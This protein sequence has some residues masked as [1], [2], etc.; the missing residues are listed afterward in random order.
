MSLYFK[1]DD[2]Q[3]GLALLTPATTA[4]KARSKGILRVTKTIDCA[5]P[6][7]EGY[8][9][10]SA[11]SDAFHRRSLA[12]IANRQP[13]N[14]DDELDPEEEEN[15]KRI[16]FLTE[17]ALAQVSEN[18]CLVLKFGICQHFLYNCKR[19]PLFAVEHSSSFWTSPIRCCKKVNR[20]GFMDFFEAY[21]HARDL[22]VPRTA[23]N[24]RSFS[25]QVKNMKMNKTVLDF[26]RR[27]PFGTW[28]VLKDDT[29]QITTLAKSK[30]F[31]GSV[32][33]PTDRY[34]E[35][36]EIEDET[37]VIE[38]EIPPRVLT[39]QSEYVYEVIEFEEDKPELA[40]RNKPKKKQMRPSN[41][42]EDLENVVGITLANNQTISNVSS[43]AH[44][45]GHPEIV[46]TS[47]SSS[48]SV[49]D[50]L[51]GN[52]TNGGGGMFGY[53]KSTTSASAIGKS[54]STILYPG[55]NTSSEAE[56]DA[57]IRRRAFI[58]P[59]VTLH[60]YLTR[61][62]EGNPAW[63]ARIFIERRYD[64]NLVTASMNGGK[65]RAGEIMVV[66]NDNLGSSGVPSTLSE[67]ALSEEQKAR[68]LG[69]AFFIVL[70]FIF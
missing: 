62:P 41:T 68:I 44:S 3:S 47:A 6:P 45:P 38:F 69:A 22:K 10:V 55:Y 49:N 5:P 63:V 13:G 58:T 66:F 26:Q 15:L 59:E 57:E 40:K 31:L 20:N 36:Y 30:P 29:V 60:K 2:S 27:S 12:A 52:A 67:K 61:I 9:V 1:D 54:E 39:A 65:L 19:M 34:G 56:I 33:V 11:S 24:M 51:E 16:S 43:N 23:L 14:N 32:T 70:F 35:Y 64:D 48:S 53:F 28:G 46:L 25:F 7:E 50:E 17:R 37:G 8:D 18:N 42:K 21:P 4:S